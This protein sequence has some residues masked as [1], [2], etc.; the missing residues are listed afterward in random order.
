MSNFLSHAFVSDKVAQFPTS[1][2]CHIFPPWQDATS[3]IHQQ[4]IHFLMHG[5]SKGQSN[6][7]LGL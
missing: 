3:N 4:K 7:N 5:S 6:S 2:G 1:H